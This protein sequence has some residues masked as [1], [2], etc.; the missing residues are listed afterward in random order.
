MSCRAILAPLDTAMP[1]ITPALIIIVWFIG[2]YW[3]VLQGL[4]ILVAFDSR[5]LFALAV[6]ALVVAVSI[7]ALLFAA[8]VLLAKCKYR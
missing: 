4:S 1:I 2:L 8:V 5:R 6:A 7:H 3:L